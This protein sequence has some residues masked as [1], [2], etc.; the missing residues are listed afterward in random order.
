MNTST[1]IAALREAR[2]P[3]S[4]PFTYL[5]LIE[6]HLSPEVLPEL[7]SI[8][9][10]ADLTQTIGWDLVNK[11]VKLPGCETCLETIARLG[12]PR[13]VILK[14]NET[15]GRLDAD[16]GYEADEE[17]TKLAAI[18]D[19]S[20]THK[21][22][23]LV[24]MLPI[25][26]SRIKTKFPSRFLADTLTAVFNAYAQNPDEEMTAAVVNMVHSLS[27]RRRPTLPSRKSSV[28]VANPAQDGDASKNAPDP[29][30][31]DEREDQAGDSAEAA[32]QQRMLLSF[33]TCVL[34]VYAN[35]NDM[36]WSGRLY[37]YYRPDKIVS[38]PGRITAL[39][40][41]RE[42]PQLLAKD[43]LI[44]QLV[45]LI[46]D[47]GL[48]SCSR[49]FIEQLR[50]G[51]VQTNPFELFEDATEPD[52]IP[53]STG[54]C[55]VLIAYWVFSST[56]FDARR[57]KP[58]M[59]IFPDHLALLD[60]VLG[61]DEPDE[62]VGALPGVVEALVALGL[63]LEENKFISSA[64]PSPLAKPTSSGEK[65]EEEPSSDF[66]RF[67]HFSTLIALYHRSKLTKNAA[68][69]LAG[70]VL[71]FNP[72]Q[73]DRLR[74]LYDILENC[75]FASVKAVALNWF[76][77]E[78]VAASTAGA[79]LDPN[80]GASS[81]S[82]GS[83]FA[84]PQAMDTVQY[85]V[86]PNLMAEFKD[87]SVEELEDKIQE[88]ILFYMQAVN[89]GLFLWLDG[90]RWEA[91]LPANLDATVRE[92]WWE[93]LVDALE[94]IQGRK[95]KNDEGE[96]I[97]DLDVLKERLRLLGEAK[98]FAGGGGSEDGEATDEKGSGG[99]KDEPVDE[100]A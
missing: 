33:V 86:F 22:I 88:Y 16:D 89:F 26:H 35:K 57:P 29:E 4:D 15:L 28:N 58:D 80:G 38:G 20:Y 84:S 54:G 87:A 75:D 79:A 19:V 41:F 72:D 47:L 52:D 27:G 59:Y 65:D 71:K 5:T 2:P 36:A 60:K 10:D 69:A 81:S 66:M 46:T 53:L 42:N 85:V 74:I 63:W 30:A 44:G 98:G 18:D 12:N 62:I 56:I 8:L 50:D 23:A 45:A 39:A 95:G 91:V 67:I 70:Q 77:D 9:Q 93:P 14:V 7:D 92:R 55:I 32:M 61:G 51:P 82:S 1:A 90:S 78:L 34:E 25:L 17:N 68:V 94:R 64:P 96:V 100:R 97:G 73:D 43:A 37:E 49:G 48:A 6:P 21:F 99:K 13:E 40:S 76:R 31:D 11:L 24:G 83:I 3:A